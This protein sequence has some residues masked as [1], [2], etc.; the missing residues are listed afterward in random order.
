ME[1]TRGETRNTFQ[2]GLQKNTE[3]ISKSTKVGKEE[4]TATHNGNKRKFERYEIEGERVLKKTKRL[5]QNEKP[6]SNRLFARK[7]NI[8]LRQQRLDILMH[9]MNCTNDDGST[10]PVVCLM[11]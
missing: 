9:Y 3:E 2:I 11:E 10:S 1:L 7:K 5:R 6:K 4:Y 8:K